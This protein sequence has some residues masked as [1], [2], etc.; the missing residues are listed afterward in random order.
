MK[1]NLP[2]PRYVLK[3]SGGEMITGAFFED[4]LVKFNPAESFE[5]KV[6]ESKKKGRTTLHLVHYIG[7]PSSMDEWVTSKQLTNL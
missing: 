7:Y 6:L 3:D 4:E 5:I 2:V 1:Y